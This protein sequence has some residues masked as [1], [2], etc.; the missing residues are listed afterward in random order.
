MGTGAQRH[1]PSPGLATSGFHVCPGLLN[2]LSPSI[3]R[4]AQGPP[5][6]PGSQALRVSDQG[7]IGLRTGEKNKST[8]SR[9]TDFSRLEPAR[10]G[11]RR[12]RPQSCR[13][14]ISRGLSDR[15]CRSLCESVGVRRESHNTSSCYPS[16]LER[17]SAVGQ[18]LSRSCT[19]AYSAEIRSVAL[20]NTVRSNIPLEWS[21]PVALPI[22]PASCL[23]FVNQS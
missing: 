6:A 14:R 17:K 7:V 4:N 22:I 13:N 16:A 18:V 20:T 21:T 11:C 12:G 3:K 5:G 1:E 10:L 2:S 23:H 19:R 8:K 9:P 15:L